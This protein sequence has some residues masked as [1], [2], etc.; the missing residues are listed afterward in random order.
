MKRSLPLV[1]SLLFCGFVFALGSLIGSAITQ[2]SS[3]AAENTP[4]QSLCPGTG[5]GGIT[6]SPT[7]IRLPSGG[8][9]G[10]TAP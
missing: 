3:E 8:L 2:H 7:S 9:G 6:G 10:S 5:H 4:C 1:L